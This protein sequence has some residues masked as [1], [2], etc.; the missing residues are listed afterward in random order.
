MQP[1]SGRKRLRIQIEMDTATVEDRADIGQREMH[2]Y[3]G[4]IKTAGL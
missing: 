1:H 4:S 2:N 3:V